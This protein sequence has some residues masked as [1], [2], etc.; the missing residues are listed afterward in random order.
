MRVLVREHRAER[1]VARAP[2]RQHALELARLANSHVRARARGG[3]AAK[4]RARGT[5]DARRIRADARRIRVDARG[6]EP[7]GVVSTEGSS[8]LFPSPLRSSPRVSARRATRP[9]PRPS[10]RAARLP[11]ARRAEKVTPPAGA[12][13]SA[14]GAFSSPP[15][16]Q[17]VRVDERDANRPRRGPRGSSVARRLIGG[18]RLRTPGRTTVGGPAERTRPEPEGLAHF[19]APATISI[20]ATPP[21]PRSAIAATTRRK[22]FAASSSVV[23]AR[24][25]HASHCPMTASPPLRRLAARLPR[26]FRARRAKPPND[27]D[28]R[29]PRSPSSRTGR[30]RRRRTP[31]GSRTRCTSPRPTPWF[32]RSDSPR[33]ASRTPRTARR[34]S[35]RSTTRRRRRG[36]RFVVRLPSRSRF[37]RR[38]VEGRRRR[39]E[40]PPPTTTTTSRRR[41]TTRPGTVGGSRRI[42]NTPR[43][44]SGR[45]LGRFRP[46]R[47]GRTR[48]R[49]A[50]RARPRGTEP[51]P[52]R[53]LVRHVGRCH[54]GI[55]PD[56]PETPAVVRSPERD[57]VDVGD[58]YRRTSRT[59]ARRVPSGISRTRSREARAGNERRAG[60]VRGR[61][62][63]RTRSSPRARGGRTRG[64]SPGRRGGRRGTPR[65]SPRTSRRG[66]RG[67]TGAP[68]APSR[69]RTRR[70]RRGT[71]RTGGTP[72]G[73]PRAR[74][75]RRGRRRSGFR[76]AR[77]APRR[78]RRGGGRARGR[79]GASAAVRDIFRPLRGIETA[80]SP[81]AVPRVAPERRA[82]RR[83]TRV[84]RRTLEPARR[85]GGRPT[86]RARGDVW[87][88]RRGS[89]DPRC[90]HRDVK[91]RID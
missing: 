53:A 25:S 71:G 24:F 6:T 4:K 63:G 90:R 9:R 51:A 13:R 38:S 30:S 32:A 67:S 19:R 86:R 26:V 1:D 43:G 27:D 41:R 58:A 55:A 33:A 18:R 83:R 10:A 54:V 85:G 29:R 78:G 11:R 88:R 59:L 7:R 52:R 35:S 49:T 15:P 46:R 82:P 60:R 61:G 31:G 91:M 28:G 17:S 36:E 62:T 72:R 12:E 75:A 22:S 64:A 56:A 20:A 69:R 76:R 74:S 34:G 66:T 8:R 14:L 42:G 79:A 70:S 2:K 48:T 81:P 84:R 21:A 57:V 45:A 39:A 44:T 47:R 50:A 65:T 23:T 37:G 68:G 77:D 87:R 3:R 73:A 40:T 89:G 5:R 80:T 16:R